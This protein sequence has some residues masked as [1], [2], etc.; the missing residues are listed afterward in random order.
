[1]KFEQDVECCSC[2]GT[3]L[4][5]GM[6]ERD[7]SAIVCHTCSGTGKEHIV[8]QYRPFTGRQKAVGIERVLQHNP[9][10]IVGKGNGK[11]S[12]DCFGGMTY[13]D[14]LKNK[15]FPKYS[16]MRNYSCPAW[17]YQGADYKKK[18]DWKECTEIL[19]SSFSQCSMF[20]CKEK[21]WEKF[22]KEN[23]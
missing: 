4:Y 6:A 8:L 15:K 12:L 5:V 11:F 1:M 13:S 18:P 10:I 17:W 9:G 23:K 7:G 14:W 16:E 22:D 21:C 2:N 3:G 19:G 20:G